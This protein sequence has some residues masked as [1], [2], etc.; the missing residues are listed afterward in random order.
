MSKRARALKDE[1]GSRKSSFQFCDP[2]TR[3]SV[4]VVLGMSS[5]KLCLTVD[6]WVSFIGRWINK[7]PRF[8]IIKKQVEIEGSEHFLIKK[9]VF[10]THFTESQFFIANDNGQFVVVSLNVGE[11]LRWF[12][13]QGQMSLMRAGRD[14]R[15]K[16]ISRLEL[17]VL[18]VIN[19]SSPLIPSDT[20]F[21]WNWKLSAVSEME[22]CR[23]SSLHKADSSRLCAHKLNLI[24]LT[25]KE[26]LGRFQRKVSQFH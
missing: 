4:D 18:A 12:S 1:N 26:F 25:L 5:I 13:G 14:G 21:R 15:K 16:K 6:L 23:T 7:Q 24:K 9:T 20:S 2:Q 3:R 8:L 10:A 11:N 19:Q 22:V 17:H